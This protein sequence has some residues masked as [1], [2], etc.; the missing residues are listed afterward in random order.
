MVGNIWERILIVNSTIWC[1]A[2]VYLVYTTGMLILT[3]AWQQ[4]LIAFLIIF[5]ATATEITFSLFA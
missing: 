1:V 2:L 4:F 5:I 3:L